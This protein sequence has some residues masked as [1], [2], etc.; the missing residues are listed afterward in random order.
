MHWGSLRASSSSC[1][2]VTVVLPPQKR[3][4]FGECP[5]SPG[6]PPAGIAFR[7]ERFGDLSPDGRRLIQ[8]WARDAGRALPAVATAVPA[9]PSLQH[10]RANAFEA[11]IYAWISFNGW[12]SCCLEDDRDTI[13][14]RVLASEPSMSDTF[15]EL[16][17]TDLRF[18][19]AE[20]RFRALWPIFRA[21][22]VRSDHLPGEPRED[23]VRRYVTDFPGAARAPD[24]H[25]R[26]VNEDLP[27]DWGHALRALYQVRCNLFHGRK[28]AFGTEDR[29]IVESA[30][31]VLVPI[32]SRL[33]LP[34]PGAPLS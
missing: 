30:A 10:G 16:V 23:R 21:T 27:A 33:V 4:G 34:R 15:N 32:V 28:S 2:T 17:R 31:D 1:G 5:R 14:V 29:D 11:F 19:D 3:P 20:R 8:R 25:L 18:A 12:A 7:V 13:Q 6:T 26:H 24:C 9:Q 22:D